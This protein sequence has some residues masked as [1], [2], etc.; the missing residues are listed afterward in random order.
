MKNHKITTKSTTFKLKK[1]INTDLES[2]IFL[3]MYE[4]V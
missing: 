3:F 4:F 1:K 2:L